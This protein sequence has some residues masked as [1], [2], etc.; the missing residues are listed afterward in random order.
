MLW[1]AGIE[2]RPAKLFPLS[3]PKF[4]L[5]GCDRLDDETFIPATVDDNLLRTAIHNSGLVEAVIRNPEGCI[6]SLKISRVDCLHGLHRV[7]AAERHLD[8]KDHWW[9]VKL[10]SK[11]KSRCTNPNLH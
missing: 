1:N 3:S 8:E 4:E 7:L 2:S 10:Y 5:E 9:V 11:G 6:S